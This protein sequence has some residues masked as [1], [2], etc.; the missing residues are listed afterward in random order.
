MTAIIFDLYIQPD[1]LSI[2]YKF[3]IAT[4][5]AEK[6]EVTCRSLVQIVYFEM[7]HTRSLLFEIE[8][9]CAEET[10]LFLKT[11]VTH[12]EFTIHCGVHDA[13]RHVVVERLGGN[14]ALFTAIEKMSTSK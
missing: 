4:A 8:L 3:L 12:P 2:V 10:H 7:F 5:T 6:V 9:F 13:D 1:R 14:F 11:V